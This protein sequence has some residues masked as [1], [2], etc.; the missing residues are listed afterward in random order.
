MRPVT[1]NA[2]IARYDYNFAI[3]TFLVHT[4]LDMKVAATDIVLTIYLSLLCD[5]RPVDFR[6]PTKFPFSLLIYEQI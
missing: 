6:N 2:E 4:A 5:T 3:L 1:A